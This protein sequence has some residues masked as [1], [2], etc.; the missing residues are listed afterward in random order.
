M[1]DEIPQF[2]PPVKRKR[3]RPSNAELV[4]RGE[5]L[6]ERKKNSAILADFK[7]QVLEHEASQKVVEKVFKIALDDEHS[8]QMGALKM[9]T[10][11]LLPVAAFEP[12]K[13]TGGASGI[14]ISINTTG[15]VNH[16]NTVDAEF[17]EVGDEE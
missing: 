2:A 5:K 6:P 7:R 1:T 11:R 4:A 9:L 8:G 17:E 3:G 13:K 14:T 12:D 16:A 15:S 10:D